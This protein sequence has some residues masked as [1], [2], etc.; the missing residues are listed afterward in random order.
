M[1]LH[2]FISCDC[3]SVSADAD[4]ASLG[5]QCTLNMG[6]NTLHPHSAQEVFVGSRTH[7]LN[8]KCWRNCEGVLSTNSSSRS[9]CRTLAPLSRVDGEWSLALAW[10]KECQRVCS[11]SG[12]VL[13]LHSAPVGER[14]HMCSRVIWARVNCI[15]LDQNRIL[16][17]PSKGKDVYANRVNLRGLSFLWMDVVATVVESYLAVDVAMSL[18]VL[19]GWHSEA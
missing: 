4:L 17:F 19:L 9:N 5:M 10:C 15:W 6:W 7:E 8:R 12:L 16:I 11:W 18:C 13:N 3:K 1:N 14:W 2:D